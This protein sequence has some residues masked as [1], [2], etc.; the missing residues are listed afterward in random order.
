MA[1]TE[2]PLKSFQ[3]HRS[4]TTRVLISIRVVQEWNQTKK[5][6][7]PWPKPPAIRTSRD[8]WSLAV[9][10]IS[11]VFHASGRVRR[12]YVPFAQPATYLQT[13]ELFVKLYEAGFCFST[14]APCSLAFFV[15]AQIQV[16]VVFLS[17]ELCLRLY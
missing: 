6:G 12:W 10:H 4:G 13:H 15:K 16:T 11:V 3:T 5:G 14:T 1:V 2:A 7:C 17:Y 8:R 9:H